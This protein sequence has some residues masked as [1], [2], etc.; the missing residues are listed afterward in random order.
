MNCT[1]V[2]P[3]V[4]TFLNKKLYSRK[5]F[6]NYGVLLIKGLNPGLAI[7]ELKKLLS[8]HVPKPNKDS[9]TVNRTATA[10]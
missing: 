8:G 10:Q 5:D 6:F 9:S 4:N 1:K 7:A 2:C 3:K